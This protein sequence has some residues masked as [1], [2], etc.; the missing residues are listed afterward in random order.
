MKTSSGGVDFSLLNSSPLGIGKGHSKWRG[1]NVNKG[2][3]SENLLKNQ[4]DIERNFIWKHHQVVNVSLF[5][6]LSPG[7][8]SQW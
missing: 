2:I 4:Q 8:G 6:S 3:Y 1:Q 5:K 7:K